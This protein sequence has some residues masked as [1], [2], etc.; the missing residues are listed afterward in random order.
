MAS[1]L[2]LLMVRQPSQSSLPPAKLPVQSSH[3]ISWEIPAVPPKAGVSV[4]GVSQGLNMVPQQEAGLN[5]K[6]FQGFAA[7][8]VTTEAWAGVGR[9]EHKQP[10]LT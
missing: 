3:D 1:H 10:P 5:T 2:S 9:S 7:L 8:G 6:S 4:L